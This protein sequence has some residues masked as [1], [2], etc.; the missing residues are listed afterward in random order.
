MINLHKQRYPYTHDEKL[1][2][3]NMTNFAA[4]DFNPICLRGKYWEFIKED[5]EEVVDSYLKSNR[6]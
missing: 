4:D 6:Q 1:L 5:I 2:I 3:Q